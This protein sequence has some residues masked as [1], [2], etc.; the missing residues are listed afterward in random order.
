MAAFDHKH[1][2]S[3]V[4]LAMAC[5]SDWRKCCVESVQ[6]AQEDDPS[7]LLSLEIRF[8][9]G[10]V[11]TMSV[12]AGTS[13]G[14]IASQLKEEQSLAGMPQLLVGGRLLDCD[15]SAGSSGSLCW[16]AVAVEPRVVFSRWRHHMLQWREIKIPM[17]T[18]YQGPLAVP[19]LCGEDRLIISP[20][21]VP[22][23]RLTVIDEFW[24]VGANEK[25]GDYDPRP[26]PQPPYVGLCRVPLPLPAGTRLRFHDFDGSVLVAVLDDPE[27]GDKR[28]DPQDNQAYTFDELSAYYKGQYSKKQ[29]S[30]YWQRSCWPVEKVSLLKFRLC[31]A[32]AEDL[33]K[34]RW[35]PEGKVQHL[36]LDLSSWGA[37]E[38]FRTEH[39]AVGYKAPA[40]GFHTRPIDS[41]DIIMKAGLTIHT[42]GDPDQEQVDVVIDQLYE[43]KLGIGL[44]HQSDASIV[45]DIVVD[46]A[47]RFW[48]LGDEVMAVNGNAIRDNGD[49]LRLYGPA[50]ESLP[51]TFTV[52]RAKEAGRLMAKFHCNHPELALDPELVLLPGENA[53]ED[54]FNDMRLFD[55]HTGNLVKTIPLDFSKGYVECEWPRGF[56]FGS[57]Q[58]FFT[59]CSEDDGNDSENS[60]VAFC[61]PTDVGAPCNAQLH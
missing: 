49:F 31:D 21:S 38:T 4:R 29:L 19:V 18:P 58:T 7:R 35:E 56:L 45:I 9:S 40:S 12:P 13:V 44:R 8:M 47:H 55:W 41:Q 17:F 2:R 48:K 52:M 3:L 11:V 51:V 39:Q 32:Y 26:A 57:S 53:G 15:A 27:P 20:P 60:L 30:D 33:G 5:F 46:D 59:A 61:T 50:K 36:D 6:T 28:V 25:S 10:S 24:L 1:G 43:G 23:G 34:V 42:D 54:A 14:R 22:S 16:S 37:V